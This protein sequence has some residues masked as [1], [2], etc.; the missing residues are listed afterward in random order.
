MP[1]SKK[2]TNILFVC[3]G[4][5]CR[6]PMAEGILKKLVTEARLDGIRAASAG[7][8]ALPGNPASTLARK[9]A[10][11]NGVDI[12]E[13]RARPVS[14]DIIDQSDLVLVMEPAHRKSLLASYPEGSFYPGG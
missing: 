5:I 11:E 9:V 10:G 6:S 3:T 12:S 13:H 8:C 4:N 2:H 7:V 1:V 14:S